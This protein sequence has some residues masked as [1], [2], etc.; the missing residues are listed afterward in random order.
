MNGYAGWQAEHT[1][2]Y[3]QRRC[4]RSG[5]SMPPVPSVMPHEGS[6]VLA[7]GARAL[8]AWRD[9]LAPHPFGFCYLKLLQALWSAGLQALRLLQ[10]THPPPP[11]TGE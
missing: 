11:H 2:P 6:R 7:C 4:A 1:A 5:H 9:V 10:H 3:P 8:R